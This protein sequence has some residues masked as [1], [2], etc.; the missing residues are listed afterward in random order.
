M[1]RHWQKGLNVFREKCATGF[2]VF[3][4]YRH[5]EE[6]HIKPSYMGLS[7]LQQFRSRCILFASYTSN[8]T[9][10]LY[11]QVD[12]YRLYS[13]RTH[14]EVVWADLTYRKQRNQCEHGR[15]DETSAKRT[16]IRKITSLSTPKKERIRIK[17][18]GVKPLEGVFVL[19]YSCSVANKCIFRRPAIM[20]ST[21]VYNIST[22]FH[23]YFLSRNKYHSFLYNS[24]L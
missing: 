17:C 6:Q 23:T 8:G 7:S 11:T 19:L 18:C 22:C 10:A 12:A 4:T 14:R 15:L 3:S 1:L 2:R 24:L 16:C 20:S 13:L 5:K 21:V 9:L